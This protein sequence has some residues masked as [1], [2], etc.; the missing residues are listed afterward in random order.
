MIATADALIRHEIQ[1]GALSKGFRKSDLNVPKDLKYV[2]VGVA[3]VTPTN[4]KY[5]LPCEPWIIDEAFKY[6]QTKF[7][8]LMIDLMK[9]AQFDPFNDVPAFGTEKFYDCCG[10]NYSARPFDIDF[11]VS[12][13]EIDA[14]LYKK[15]GFT[16]AM[17]D[18]VERRYSYDD[19]AG[20]QP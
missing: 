20:V 2:P 8:R 5:T 11:S 7:F 3:K 1:V 6:T 16:R 19:G 18:F 15:Y 13:P 4:E 17:I 9:L 12:V 14:Q 10:E